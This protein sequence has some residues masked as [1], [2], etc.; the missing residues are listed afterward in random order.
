MKF[1]ISESQDR[2]VKLEKLS[3][4]MYNLTKTLYPD[5]Y[6]HD[7][8]EYYPENY[9]N[10]DAEIEVYSNYDKDLLLFYYRY[11]EKAFYIGADFL[12]E[13]YSVTKLDVFDIDNIINDRDII[14][15]RRGFDDM[16][17]LFAK[18][19]YGWDVNNVW[20]HWH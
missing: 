20:F 16:I 10:E 15:G 7:K 18:R 3:D 6:E 17:K 19:H 12:D 8:S 1:I 4:L 13:L 14:G 2:L 5:L 9:S 11:D